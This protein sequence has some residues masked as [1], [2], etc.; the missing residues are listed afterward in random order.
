MRFN[1]AFI[2]LASLSLVLAQDKHA[3]ASTSAQAPTGGTPVTSTAGGAGGAGDAGAML[4]SLP[5]CFTECATKA[6]TS[7]TVGCTGLTD[8]ACLCSKPQFSNAVSGLKEFKKQFSLTLSPPSK[9]T[10]NGLHFF[11]RSK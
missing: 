2:V 6:A 9:N 1:V 7:A 10:D 3:P 8:V 11:F 4:S 5:K